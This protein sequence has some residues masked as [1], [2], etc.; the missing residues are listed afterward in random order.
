MNEEVL[1]ELKK[2]NSKLDSIINILSKSA[3]GSS[4]T[5]QVGNRFSRT[6]DI[7]AKIQEQIAQARQEVSSRV[8]ID[9]TIISE[10]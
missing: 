5:D 3:H 9:P 2:L 4:N 6:S 1:A 10:I 7:K 8:R